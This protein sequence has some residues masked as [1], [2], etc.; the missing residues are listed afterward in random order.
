MDLEQRISN[1][2]KRMNSQKKMEGNQ[3]NPCYHNCYMASTVFN[4][5]D[6][7]SNCFIGF[8]ISGGFRLLG[9][10]LVILEPLH[11]RML[12]ILSNHLSTLVQ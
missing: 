11:F 12:S 2:E 8:L 6:S 3:K 10:R 4:R 9:L 7:I 1:L 5:V